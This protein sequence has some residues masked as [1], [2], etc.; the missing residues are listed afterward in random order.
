MFQT[1]KKD[2]DIARWTPTAAF[3][4]VRFGFDTFNPV[5]SAYLDVL[6][7]DANV[8]V[9]VESRTSSGK[10]AIAEMAIARHA[11]A[12]GKAAIYLAPLKSLTQEKFDD[13]TDRGHSFGR[14]RCIPATGDHAVGDQRERLM[15]DALAS[16]IILM[17]TE[18]FDSISRRPERRT[19]FFARCGV[20]I[21]DEAH[22]LTMPDRG[23]ALEVALMRFTGVNPGAKVLFLS[24]TMSNSHDLAGWLAVLN[25]KKS[26]LIKSD[27]R[28]CRLNLH[29]SAVPD[30]GWTE[31]K[32]KMTTSVLDILDRHPDDKFLV[33]VHSKKYGKELCDSLKLRGYRTQFHNADLSKEDRRAF[34]EQFRQPKKSGGLDV[35]VATST[36]A[37]GANLPAR[38]VII[39]GTQ[40]GPE[41]VS[42]LDILQ[43]I[44]R[45]GRVGIDPMGDAY[46]LVHRSLYADLKERLKDIPPI[47]SRLRDVRELVFHIISEIYQGV[48]T[49]QALGDWFE[50]SFATYLWDDE[51]GKANH[52]TSVLE[53]LLECGAIRVNPETAR[54]E[55]TSVGKA[56]AL[57]YYAPDLV[58]TMWSG[59]KKVSGQIE[60]DDYLLSWVLGRAYEPA[61]VSVDHPD[62][63]SFCVKLNGKVRT[64]AFTSKKANLGSPGPNNSAMP[65][66][67]WLL[68]SERAGR[69]ES[70]MPAMVSLVAGVRFDGERLA[71]M[72][73]SLNQFSGNQVQADFRLMGLRLKH[74]VARE[75]V[76]LCRIPGVKTARARKLYDHGF[77]TVD[78]VYHN[79][80]LASKVAGVTILK[81]GLSSHLKPAGFA[82]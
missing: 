52:I 80:D 57:F 59:L 1:E 63:K 25:G 48:A 76:D 42:I 27:W 36:L 64:L 39:A 26:V 51:A 44:G 69:L 18:M 43:M 38:R 71:Q 29:V 74:G 19:E 17:T 73:T 77:K 45:A 8:N 13:W 30:G 70:E 2:V 28:P 82:I 47:E 61:R 6:A 22:L 67:F 9:V 20:L 50:R 62:F 16:D 21:V 3:P 56:A 15:D 54:F 14:H 68:L 46:I 49:G 4:S 78:D 72:L 40:R 55:V 65:F 24:A 41:D 81:P 31:K 35:L 58:A 53:R 10:T 75:L 11:L 32:V 66:A 23:A 79:T 5:Q 33:F 34:V 37:W 60:K 12:Q 7:R